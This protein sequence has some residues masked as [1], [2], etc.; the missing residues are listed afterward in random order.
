MADRSGKG[1]DEDQVE[2]LAS[3]MNNLDTQIVLLGSLVD[4]EV[5]IELRLRILIQII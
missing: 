1:L 5:D 2:V 4:E 3:V